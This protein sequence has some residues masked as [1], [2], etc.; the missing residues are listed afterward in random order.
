MAKNSIRDFDSSSGNNTD[1]QS[2][3][4]AEGCPP[5]GINN[6][7][8][9]LMADLAD[10]NSGAVALQTPAAD[11]LTIGTSN[12]DMNGN[13]IILDADG[14]T[15]ITADT[16]DR[17][18]IRVAGADLVRITSTG[19]VVGGT[20]DQS[21][22]TGVGGNSGLLVAGSD[23]ATNVA[24]NSSAN[25]TIAN[26]NGTTDNTAAVHF[27]RQDTDGTPNYASASIVAQMG[28]QTT[29]QYSTGSL[30]FLTSTSA[31][32]APSEKMTIAENGD[33]TMTGVL[34]AAA[35]ES[36]AANG[37]VKLPSGIYIQWGVNGATTGGGSTHSFPVA[38]PNNVWVITGSPNNDTTGV[39]IKSTSLSQFKLTSAGGTPSINW[40][41]IGN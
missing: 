19:L 41:A 2:V 30:H 40:I 27:A 32:A 15:S 5:S 38:F 17:V 16:D 18:D 13:E 1:I 6:A 9:E 10:V 21:V 4:V 8:R 35:T 23:T 20:L 29:G 7:I 11:G 36:K 33:V 37:Y 26:T 31:N 22:T 25:I 39:E 14:D 28:A 3:N 34:S 24:N 12:L